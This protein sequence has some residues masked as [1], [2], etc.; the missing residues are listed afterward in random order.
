MW[1]FPLIGNVD[2]CLVNLRDCTSSAKL[3]CFKGQELSNTGWRPFAQEFLDA[4]CVCKVRLSQVQHAHASNTYDWAT[5]QWGWVQ[6][7][8]VEL[9][10]PEV[11][12]RA[13][14]A[15]PSI[16]DKTCS[17]QPVSLLLDIS[18]LAIVSHRPAAARAWHGHNLAEAC[19]F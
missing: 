6:L 15:R 19:L 16:S 9:L 14:D 7:L 4:A 2:L 8:G 3:R 13:V 17:Y 11:S 18:I 12:H 10:V 1:W 5:V